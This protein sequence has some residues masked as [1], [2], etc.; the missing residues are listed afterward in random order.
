VAGRIGTRLKTAP[1]RVSAG[2]LTTADA[3][4]PCL[5]GRQGCNGGS[6][7]DLQW[8]T[9]G[10]TLAMAVGL[11]AG[12]RLGDMFGRKRM[13]LIG[14]VGFTVASVACA[15]APSEGALI[16]ARIV[17]GFQP[18]AEKLQ[19][20]GKLDGVGGVRA[21]GGH[22]VASGLRLLASSASS[23]A[24]RLSRNRLLSR[25]PVRRSSTQS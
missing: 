17:V 2:D 24:I 12:G 8:L 16:T 9:A 21:E 4:R 6:Y 1:R 20:F 5:L 15:L 14:A 22:Y 7:A 23:S 19:H 25:A 3:W 11:L 18:A 13:L 10:Y